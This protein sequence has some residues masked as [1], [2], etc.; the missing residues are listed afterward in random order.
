VQSGLESA[1]W[2]SPLVSRAR[3]FAQVRNKCPARAGGPAAESLPEDDASSDH[4]RPL[5][6]PDGE[7]T[8]RTRL[9]SGDDIYGFPRDKIRSI[10]SA[11]VVM[12]G[13]SS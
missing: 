13:R 1:N 12:T 3:A 10:T 6:V 5:P 7:T 11:P 2:L 9:R 4:L 8:S